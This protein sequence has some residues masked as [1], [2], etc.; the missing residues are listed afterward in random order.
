M[1]A[2]S[3]IRRVAGVSPGKNSCQSRWSIHF[4]FT[5][6]YSTTIELSYVERRC[7]GLADYILQPVGA[8]LG[9][10]H[11]VAKRAVADWRSQREEHHHQERLFCKGRTRMFLSSADVFDRTTKSRLNRVRPS[12]LRTQPFSPHSAVLSPNS[13]WLLLGCERHDPAPFENPSLETYVCSMRRLSQH[14]MLTK[15][16]CTFQCTHLADSYTTDMSTPLPQMLP[17]LHT[18]SH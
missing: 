5:T 17:R 12:C 7:C 3:W 9:R 16:G 11:S 13:P 4:H 2:P 6:L 1:R 15:R 14:I 10:R 8:N 18:L